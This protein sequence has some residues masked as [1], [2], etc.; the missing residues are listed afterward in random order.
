MRV[1]QGRGWTI[2]LHGYQHKYVTRDSDVIGINNYSE[3]AGLL[4][5]V[6]AFKLRMAF[7]IFRREGIRP[8][9]WDRSS[10]FVRSHYRGPFERSAAATDQRQILFVPK[11]G[12]SW[13]VLDPT[14]IVALPTDA[15]RRVVRV[16][17]LQ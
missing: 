12:L 13:H 2:G 6:Q 17:V 10:T 7:E 5:D 11:P 15:L 8:E 1:W 3:F 16:A 14:A 4:E 9:V